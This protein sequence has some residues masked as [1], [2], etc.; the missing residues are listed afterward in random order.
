MKIRLIILLC[1]F[2]V[3]N[4]IR[5]QVHDSLKYISVGPAGFQEALHGDDKPLLID[6]REFFEYKKSRIDN[7][8]NVPSSANLDNYA[9]TLNKDYTLLLYCT[10]GFRSKRVAK[11]FYDRGFLKLYSLDGGIN[12]W[13]KEGYPV[14][15]KKIRR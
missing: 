11:H 6:V 1:L 4:V 8:V 9:D 5:A 14:N 7:A 15:R 2:L 3:S 12:A 10:S 13:R